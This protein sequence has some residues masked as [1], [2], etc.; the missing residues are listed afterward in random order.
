MAKMMKMSKSDMMT[1][2]TDMRCGPS[3]I[4]WGLVGAGFMAGAL[5]V[6]VM[7]IYMQWTSML[8]PWW[9]IWAY[10]F[11]GFVLLCIGKMCKMKCCGM[12][13]MA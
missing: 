7:G 2:P 9:I 3:C 5:L 1:C 10:Y 4:G 12:C 8:T 11:G 13:K 6:L